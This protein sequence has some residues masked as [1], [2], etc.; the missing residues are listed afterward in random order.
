MTS[1]DKTD[2]ETDRRTLRISLIAEKQ[3]DTVLEICV[4]MLSADNHNH[5][6]VTDYRGHRQ[7]L[8]PVREIILK[9]CTPVILKQ[10]ILPGL[11]IE[12]RPG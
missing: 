6:T 9:A 2:L 3:F 10:F 5:L 8:L 4:V 11:G 7:T 12:P 1:E